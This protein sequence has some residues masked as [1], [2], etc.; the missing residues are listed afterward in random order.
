[1]ITQGQHTGAAAQI[2]AGDVSFVYIGVGANDFSPMHGSTYRDIYSGAAT[3][4]QVAAKV[5]QAVR[6]VTTGVF[7]RWQLFAYQAP[8]FRWPPSRSPPPA[9]SSNP[10]PPPRR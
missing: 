10:R 7:L 1:M 9:R 8:G 3:P 4:A 2:A 6:D 5:A